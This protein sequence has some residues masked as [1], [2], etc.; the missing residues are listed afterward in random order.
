SKANLQLECILLK[1]SHENELE[2]LKEEHQQIVDKLI[3][4]HNS[5]CQQ[6]NTSLLDKQQLL[7]QTNLELDNLRNDHTMLLLEKETLNK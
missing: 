3:Q 1:K 4:E 5:Q 7:A 6:Y 2:T